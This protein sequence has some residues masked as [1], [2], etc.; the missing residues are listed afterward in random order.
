MAP[1]GQST[2]RDWAAAQ[3]KVR[4]ATAWPGR[5]VRMPAVPAAWR[6]VL[7]LVVGLAGA[8][9]PAW[10]QSGSVGGRVLDQASLS[11][12]VGAQVV[13]VGTK[14]GALTGSDGRFLIAGVAGGQVEV[15]AV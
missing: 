5:R 13:V 14:Q 10:G 15:Q 11:P 9:A 3:A 8:A 12:L 2:I 7:C 1:S 4:R 6:P